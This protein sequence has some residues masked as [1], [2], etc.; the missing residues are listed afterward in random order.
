MLRQKY[1]RTVLIK[2]RNER[3]N[4]KEKLNSII[5]NHFPIW[6]FNRRIKYILKNYN[7]Q[8][9]VVIKLIREKVVLCIQ[10]YSGTLQ[11][12]IHNNIECQQNSVRHRLF[13]IRVNWQSV[14]QI[15]RQ[16][17]QRWRLDL[18]ATSSKMEMC[19]RWASSCATEE[20]VTVRECSE[21]ES[22]PDEESLTQQCA[23]HGIRSL[24]PC[25]E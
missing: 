16:T 24:R 9:A 3:I 17:G 7:T 8:R 20:N 21:D 11:S 14:E 5:K 19:E 12:N 25:A 18:L 22:P 6:G 15:T 4:D 13:R 1:I 2:T 10:F 23:G